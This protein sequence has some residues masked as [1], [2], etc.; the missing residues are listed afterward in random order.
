MARQAGKPHAAAF[1]FF[2]EMEAHGHKHDFE[3]MWR[4]LRAWEEVGSGE[5]LKIRTHR[6]THKEHH[7]LIFRY[8]PL[9]YLRGRYRLGCRLMET[10]LE[11]A[12][13]R[14]GWSFEWL[15]HVYKP[16][17]K[18]TSTYD[19]T[20]F[21]FYSALGRDL[22]EW[23]LW[24]KFLD[25]FDPS[26]FRNSGVAK[27]AMLRNP[28]LIKRFFE[29]ITAERRKRLFTG[30]TDGERDLIESPSKV[31]RRQATRSQELRR[32]AEHPGLDHFEQRLCELFP[33]LAELPQQLSLGQYF[34]ARARER[35]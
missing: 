7:Q 11:M 29:W 14:K 17:S 4:T 16:L 25:G 18:P 15:W 13:H 22:S 9:L 1:T 12:S 3:A 30:T 23:E 19:V 21:N 24:G 26:L 2:W 32:V 27:E 33:E 10:A 20:L 34:R 6:W 8:V 5:R 31:Q 28:R 35:R